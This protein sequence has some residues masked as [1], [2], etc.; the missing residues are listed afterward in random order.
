M[1]IDQSSALSPLGGAADRLGFATLHPLVRAASL[2]GAARIYED[3]HWASDVIAGAAVGTIVSRV[4]VRYVRAH[5]RNA[6]DRALL[7]RGQARSSGDRMIVF[8]WN[9]VW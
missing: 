6:I 9:Y 3:R 1:S 5:P 4:V 2:V 8:A 7:R